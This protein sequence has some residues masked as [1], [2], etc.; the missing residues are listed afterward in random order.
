MF[1]LVSYFIVVHEFFVD[2]SPFAHFL[3]TL[4]RL[5]FC[6]GYKRQSEQNVGK[7]LYYEIPTGYIVAF[8]HFFNS[9]ALPLPR[10]MVKKE[11]AR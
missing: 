11:K 8:A 2:P 4:I 5:A 9:V 3:D 1:I 10:G 6:A 7:I